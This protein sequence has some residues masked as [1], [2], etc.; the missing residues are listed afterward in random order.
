MSLGGI[1]MVY[2]LSGNSK[3][4]IERKK[5]ITQKVIDKEFSREN[6]P[7]NNSWFGWGGENSQNDNKKDAFKNIRQLI[8]DSKV[9]DFSALHKYLFDEIDSYATGHIASVI[10]ILAE[11]QYQD[12]FA[13]D[14]ELHI[15]STIVKLLNELK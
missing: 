1:V 4:I 8:N 15:M 5:R 7:Q 2:L 14:K 9:K 6:P 13:V 12:S 3:K 10:L 11:S